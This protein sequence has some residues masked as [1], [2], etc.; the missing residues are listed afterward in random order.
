MD[1]LHASLTQEYP[2]HEFAYER[3]DEPPDFW[4]SI[5]GTR[6]FAVEVTHLENQNKRT[7]QQSLDRVIAA[8]DCE[9]QSAGCITGTYVV[10]FNYLSS[11]YL[12]F[13]DAPGR[14]ELR[15][16]ILDYVSRTQTTP[17]PSPTMIE[18]NARLC[19]LISKLHPEG[20]VI[21]WNGVDS[22]DGGWGPD[23]RERLTSYLQS[24][25]PRKAAVASR[26]GAPTILVL[27]DLFR[28][29]EPVGFREC[30][31]SIPE[32]TKFALIYVVQ[33]RGQGFAVEP[34]TI[35]RLFGPTP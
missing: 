30:V 8:A 22:D 2:G 6:R 18:I 27:Y 3:G 5:D 17:R 29:T 33:D 13:M 34:A 31:R 9:A 12:S 16:K 7:V 23:I 19:G 24:A 32:S 4:L 25:L 35:E 1:E 21:G 28:F 14:A 15:R 26:V 11:H 10:E 20:A